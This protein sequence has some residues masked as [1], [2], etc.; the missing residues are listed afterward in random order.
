MRIKTD[1]NSNIISINDLI[2]NEPIKSKLKP[3]I[4]KTIP[5]SDIN[6]LLNFYFT[7]KKKES[8]EFFNS[9]PNN[10]GWQ[11]KFD[12]KDEKII[13]LIYFNIYNITIEHGSEF[14]YKRDNNHLKIKCLNISDA[15]NVIIDFMQDVNKKIIKDKKNLSLNMIREF[16][17]NYIYHNENLA[18]DDLQYLF[19]NNFLSIEEI[20]DVIRE[21][22]SSIMDEDYFISS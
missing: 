14:F 11:Y 3:N 16:V 8:I 7:K 19:K 9:I 6:D 5:V 20:L 18:V 4:N 15:K 12:I 17:V 22:F 10:S 21:E 1:E 2:L 13:F